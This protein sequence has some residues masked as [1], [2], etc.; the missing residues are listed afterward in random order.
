MVLQG[1]LACDEGVLHARPGDR[2]DYAESLTYFVRLRMLQEGFSLGV[3]FAASAALG[4]RIR[5][6]LRAPQPLRWWQRVSRTT[7]GLAMLGT[8]AALV[9]A[10]TV[11]F[12]F[13][14]T[15]LDQPSVTPLI[16]Q[17]PI[18]N[19]HSS[20]RALRRPAAQPQSPDTLTTLGA[21]KYIPETPAYTMTSGDSRSNSRGSVDFETP[22]WK[23]ST[24]SVH[25]PS[26]SNV[27]LT[28]LGQ[29][30]I[31]TRRGGRGR[32]SDDH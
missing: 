32:D 2:A 30:A 4:L 25:L 15:D 3:D 22:V 24:S 8:L 7:A 26:A 10:L 5:S 16:A 19:A 12:R 27:V 13:A 23:E 1:E 18:A 29:I 31:S 20:H 14:P 9:P 28:T 17:A 11:L 6:I 21:Q